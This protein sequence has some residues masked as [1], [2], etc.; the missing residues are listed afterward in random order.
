MSMIDFSTKGMTLKFIRISS[1][2][3]LASLKIPQ[4]Y[5]G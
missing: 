1:P 2:Q 4:G 3:V 5:D